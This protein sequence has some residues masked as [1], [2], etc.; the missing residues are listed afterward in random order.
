MEKINKAEQEIGEETE[1]LDSIQKDVI[2]HLATYED[3]LPRE[4]AATEASARVSRQLYAVKKKLGEM[5]TGEGDSLA[6]FGSKCVAMHRQVRINYDIHNFGSYI[7]TLINSWKY[8]VSLTRR[9]ES[10]CNAP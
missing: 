8:T 6:M 10:A 2:D 5:K 9:I 4:Q 7:P 3:I 1:R